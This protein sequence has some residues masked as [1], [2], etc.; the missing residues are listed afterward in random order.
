MHNIIQ[1]ESF[2][3]ITSNNSF[4]WPD[5]EKSFIQK[6]YGF[7]GEP[8]W[9]IFQLLVLTGSGLLQPEVVF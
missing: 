8:K 5:I 3:S 4:G 9:R 7:E 6:L 1:G 2:E